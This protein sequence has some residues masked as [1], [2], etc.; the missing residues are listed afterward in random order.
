MRLPVAPLLPALQR[1]QQAATRPQRD[2]AVGVF[3]TVSHPILTARCAAL[4]HRYA[5]MHWQ[6][7]EDLAGDTLLPL[8]LAP[9]RT[10]ACRATT[11]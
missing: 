11:P 8:V 9:Q 5:P 4:L 3:Y 6:S 10:H 7:P 1:V 2:D